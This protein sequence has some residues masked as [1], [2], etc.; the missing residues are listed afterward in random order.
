MHRLYRKMTINGSYTFYTGN[1][2]KWSFF[3]ALVKLSLYIKIH[4]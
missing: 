1:D 3:N 4:L 2:I